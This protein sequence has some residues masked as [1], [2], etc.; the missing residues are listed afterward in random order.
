MA[1]GQNSFTT[2]EVLSFLVDNYNV[3]GGG[4]CSDMEDEVEDIDFAVNNFREMREVNANDGFD[5][6]DIHQ[7]DVVDAEIESGFITRP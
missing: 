5:F 7:I 3:P 1:R 4:E 6:D 2:E